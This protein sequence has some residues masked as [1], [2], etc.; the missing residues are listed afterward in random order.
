MPETARANGTH[1]THSHAFAG[2]MDESQHNIAAL[3]AADRMPHV[4]DSL[5]QPVNAELMQGTAYSSLPS[6]S[7]AELHHLTRYSLAEFS[8]ADGGSSGTVATRPCQSLRAWMPDPE[9]R[10]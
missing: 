1:C 3:M 10:H 5:H 8:G 6:L 2:E 7:V 4:F 9:T